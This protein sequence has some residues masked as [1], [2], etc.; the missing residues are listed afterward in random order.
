MVEDETPLEHEPEEAE[1]AQS[2]VVV[3]QAATNYPMYIVPAD[4]KN[5]TQVVIY[6]DDSIR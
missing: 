3:E 5:K 4:D 2:E 1:E 6:H